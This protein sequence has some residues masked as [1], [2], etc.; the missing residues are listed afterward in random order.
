MLVTSRPHLRDV[1]NALQHAKRIDIKAGLSDS[2]LDSFDYD[3]GCQ[4]DPSFDFACLSTNPTSFES[5]P[6]HTPSIKSSR[7]AFS[8]ISDPLNP[9]DHDLPELLPTT[10]YSFPD[11]STGNDDAWVHGG[12]NDHCVAYMHGYSRDISTGSPAQ[13]HV[14]STSRPTHQDQHG[15]SRRMP[16]HRQKAQHAL[17][18]SCSL[19]PDC[20][21]NDKRVPT[22]VTVFRTP[23]T[24]RPRRAAS[25]TFRV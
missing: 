18:L 2:L 25:E 9:A 16:H 6:I 19:S 13:V 1:H 14:Q 22:L 24:T 4:F 5:P 3:A 11:S 23:Q 17:H 20:G 7:V 21:P 10:D 15:I 8:Q 12:G